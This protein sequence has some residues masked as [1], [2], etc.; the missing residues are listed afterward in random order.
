MKRF[1]LLFAAILLLTV[2]SAVFFIPLNLANKNVEPE[3]FVGISFCGNTVTQAKLLIDRTKEY[4]NLFVLQSFPISRNESAIYE[5]CDYAVAQGL[6]IIINLGT[7]DNETWDWHY[8]I[9]L[10][11]KTRWGNQFK[12]VYYDDEPGGI[13][14]DY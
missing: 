14:L 13:Q 11:G 8:E 7:Y 9:F 10:N 3:C 6:N 5:I 4:T 12:G 1:Y 2:V